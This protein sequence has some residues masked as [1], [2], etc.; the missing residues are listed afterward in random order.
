ME[1]PQTAC[2]LLPISGSYASLTRQYCLNAKCFSI[3]PKILN[4]KCSYRGTLSGLWVSS[5]IMSLCW[6]GKEQ[7]TAELETKEEAGEDE[8]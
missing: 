2:L 4:P 7:E 3:T 5:D 1:E 8:V 6:E